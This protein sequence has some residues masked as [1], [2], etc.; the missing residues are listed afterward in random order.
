MF[1]RE[2]ILKHGYSEAYQN[3][4]VNAVKLFYNKIQYK[5]IEVESIERPR[6]EKRLPHVLSKEEVKLII[7]SLNNLK[8]RAMLSM[9]YACGLRRSEL[10]NLKLTDIDSNRGV[11]V[12]RQ[13]KGKKDKIQRV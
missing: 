3:Q 2:Y 6:R 7:E 5:K 13:S 1:N 10:L 12:I 4:F 9:I 11:V 8:H